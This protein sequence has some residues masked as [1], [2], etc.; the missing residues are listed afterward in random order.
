MTGGMSWCINWR[1]ERQRSKIMLSQKPPANLML[2]WLYTLI[3]LYFVKKSTYG[4]NSS[5]FHDFISSTLFKPGFIKLVRLKTYT[6]GF[7]FNTWCGNIFS[8]T[9]IPF[10]HIHYLWGTKKYK[11]NQTEWFDPL[12]FSMSSSQF[13]YVASESSSGSKW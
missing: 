7:I 9:A 6:G 13:W 5:L 10:K 2:L 11:A 8:Q 12:I 3:I 1:R 4:N